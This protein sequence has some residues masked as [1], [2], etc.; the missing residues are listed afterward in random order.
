MYCHLPS[1][2]EVEYGPH[3]G[4]VVVVV[5]VFVVVVVAVVVACVV[6]CVGSISL[7]I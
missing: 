5:V 1:I 7:S 3:L 4:L 2:F 6:V